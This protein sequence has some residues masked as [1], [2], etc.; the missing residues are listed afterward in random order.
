[1]PISVAPSESS[2][3]AS[4][5]IRIGAIWANLAGI[6]SQKEANYGRIRTQGRS[7]G[8]NMQVQVTANDIAEGHRGMSYWCPIALALKRKGGLIDGVG[9]RWINYKVVR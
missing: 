9:A 4:Y 6:D 3:R 1:M 8:A 7:G 2:L 5:Q